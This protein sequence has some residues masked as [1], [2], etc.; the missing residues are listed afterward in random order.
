MRCDRCGSQAE[1]T[2][3]SLGTL[4]EFQVEST[5]KDAEVIDICDQCVAAAAVTWN[6]FASSASSGKLEA[7]AETTVA[8]EHGQVAVRQKGQHED[9][10]SIVLV[11]VSQ[12]EA[13]IRLLRRAV[14]PVAPERP[15]GSCEM[16][17]ERPPHAELVLTWREGRGG[18]DTDALGFEV[19]SRCAPSVFED[20]DEMVLSRG[21]PERGSS[22][23]E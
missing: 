19:C 22:E 13:L 20:W 12:V 7:V 15:A 14:I 23:E 8:L 6:G 5:V 1:L 17:G 10:D 18:E 9:D 11:P 4:R 21:R 16:C 3:V 2:Q